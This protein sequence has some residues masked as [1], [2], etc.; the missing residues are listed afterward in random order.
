MTAK[1]V[2]FEG[3]DGSG[4]STLLSAV[5]QSLEQMGLT[6]VRGRMISAKGE[7]FTDL[8][9]FL[10]EMPRA[11]YCDTVAFER[12][13]RLKAFIIENL[14]ADVLLFDRYLYSDLAYAH[15]YRCATTFIEAL[16]AASRAPDLLV[17]CD[18]PLSIAL[19]RIRQRKSIL[20]FQENESA[21]QGTLRAYGQLHSSGLNMFVADG[22]ADVLGV[23]SDV[24][25]AICQVAGYSSVVGE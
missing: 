8:V 2:C 14:D 13:L 6:A 20:L 22:C 23:A 1:V 10:D 24:V 21:L 19:H 9:S 25:G 11:S 17:Y 16:I 4:K 15:S 18:V 7:F 5:K 12:Y 3:I